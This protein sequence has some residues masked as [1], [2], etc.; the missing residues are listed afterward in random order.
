MAA[1]RVPPPTGMGV[2]KPTSNRE[3]AAQMRPQRSSLRLPPAWPGWRGG[4]GLACWCVCSRWR[5]WKPRSVSGFVANVICLNAPVWH[6]VSLNPPAAVQFRVGRNSVSPALTAGHYGRAVLLRII[7]SCETKPARRR[8][9]AAGHIVSIHAA[10]RLV[11][12][13]SAP[14]NAFSRCSGPIWI[15]SAEMNSGLVTPIKP[16]TQRK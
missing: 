16:N 10:C 15:P 13:C 5:K 4:I 11:A 3:M 14:A 2:R 8:N 7:T 9:R 1:G 12:A 6:R